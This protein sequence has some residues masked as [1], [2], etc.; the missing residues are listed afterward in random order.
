V[1][2]GLF[3]TFNIS[4]GTLVKGEIFGI[5]LQLTF[6]KHFIVVGPGCLSFGFSLLCFH[7]TANRQMEKLTIEF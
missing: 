2:C 7:D 4:A 3:A 5:F 1:R 6:P